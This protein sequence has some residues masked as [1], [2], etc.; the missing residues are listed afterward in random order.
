MD[1]DIKAITFDARGTLVK[2]RFP[3]G[4]TYAAVARRHGADLSVESIEEAFHEALPSMPPLAFPPMPE[5]ELHRREHDWWRTL[6]SRV[7]ETAGRVDDFKTF[8][9]ELYGIYRGA[10]AWKPYREAASVLCLLRSSRFKLGL[11]SN[12]DSRIEEILLAL[13]LSIWFDSVVFSSRAGVSKPH[14]GIFRRALA[15]L[16][17]EPHEALHVGDSYERDYQGATA[18]GMQAML[19][20]RTGHWQGRVPEDVPRI[21]GLEEILEKLGVGGFALFERAHAS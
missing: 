11:I 12:F 16:D 18:V 6:V 21:A 5:Q 20:D 10:E 3:V 8:F 9:A 4:E 17:V 2:V 13:N 7:V 15:E 1:G 19:V 14:P